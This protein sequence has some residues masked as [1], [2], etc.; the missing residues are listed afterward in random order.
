MFQ[1]IRTRPLVLLFL[2]L[3]VLMQGAAC[4][5]DEVPASSD[6]AGTATVR[7]TA[8]ATSPAT[9]LMPRDPLAAASGEAAELGEEAT[10]A[11][12]ASAP[13]VY[14]WTAVYRGD[15]SSYGF[16]SSDGRTQVAVEGPNDDPNSPRWV[17]KNSD[18]LPTPVGTP[19]KPL[20][21]TALRR[22]PVEVLRLFS[23][24]TG[25]AESDIFLQ[26]QVDLDT[27]RPLWSAGPISHQ[28]L[29]PSER[30]GPILCMLRD[31]D[32]TWIEPC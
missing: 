19:P 22:S 8:G 15:V 6:A 21:L 24:K 4:G 14:L 5:K 11:A 32:G 13:E 9:P 7:L 18:F 25:L 10:A 30:S 27:G 20:D 26:V 1:V 12:H 16:I 2:T 31:M 3:L 17:I 23:Q 28:P 29:P